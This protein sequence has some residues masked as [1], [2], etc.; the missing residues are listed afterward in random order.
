[1]RQ[2]LFERGLWEDAEDYAAWVKDIEYLKKLNSEFLQKCR[3]LDLSF[4]EITDMDTTA[5]AI[6]QQR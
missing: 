1:M 6:L 2:I 3:T 4:F 5:K